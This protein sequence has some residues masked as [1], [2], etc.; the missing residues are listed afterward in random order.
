MKMRSPHV[1]PLSDQVLHILS[2]LHPL[3]GKGKYVF[4]G[5]RSS[6]RPMSENTITGA[7]RRL[8]YTKDEMTGH[9]FRSIASTRLNEMG[10]NRDA[11]ERQLAHAERDGIRAA[12]NYADYIDDRHEMMQKW[13]DYLDKLKNGSEITSL[14]DWKAKKAS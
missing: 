2:E 14:Q 11:I 9:G 4:P 8:G 5:V 6:L 12:Y 3:T 13:A 10:W 7:L 1:V